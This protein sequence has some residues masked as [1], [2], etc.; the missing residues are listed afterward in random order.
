MRG[1]IAVLLVALAASAQDP[2]QDPLARARQLIAGKKP[3]EALELLRPLSLAEPP[4]P[5]VFDAMGEACRALRKYGDALAAYRRL[6]ELKP[7]STDAVRWQALMHARLRQ[8]PAAEAKYRRLLAAREND[9][10]SRVGLAYT[11]SLQRKLDEAATE[12]HKA[13][14]IKPDLADAR[15]R[16][17]WILLWRQDFAKAAAEFERVLAANADDVEAGLGLAAVDQAQDRVEA[18]ENRLADLA[19]LHPENMDVFMAYARVLRRSGKPDES[20]DAARRVLDSGDDP[21]EAHM[22]LGELAV[23][24][25]RHREGEGHYRAVLAQEPDH[26]GGLTGLA[27]ALRRQGK[28]EEARRAYRSILEKEPDHLNARIGLAWQHAWDGNYPAAASEFYRVLGRDPRNVDALAGIARVRFLQGRWD[29]S[30]DLYRRALAI[31]PY[32]GSVRE[33]FQM[34]LEA[35]QVR[36]RLS[37]RHSEEFERDQVTERDAIRLVSNVLSNSWRARLTLDTSVDLEARASYGREYNRIL[38]GD[39]YDYDYYAVFAGVHHRIADPWTLSARIGYGEFTNHDSRGG[40]RFPSGEDFLEAGATVAAEWSDHALSL[41]W[42]RSPLVIKDFPTF[43]LGVLALDGMA[44]RYVS[45]W[46]KD[47]LTPE[48]HENQV[49]A[50]ARAAFYSDDNSKVGFETTLRHRLVYDNGWRVGPFAGIRY[51][52][53]EEDVVFYYSYDR[54]WRLA[55]GIQVDY[56]DLGVWS[57]MARYTGTH[58]ITRE[59]V[60]PGQQI[61]D[62]TLPIDRTAATVTTDGSV[63]EARAVWTPGGSV[64]LGADASYSWD[65]NHYIT[66]G[67]G[68]FVEIGF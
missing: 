52:D 64:R 3:A 47:G 8:F 37:L 45:P 54:Q 56:E 68:L 14:A 38:R 31:D 44:L 10:E 55:G 9:L 26:M 65:N 27:T 25:Q 23:Q 30:T 11:L 51:A 34:A 35:G 59:R 39:N 46:W 21:L 41:E 17:G 29:E 20:A 28:R 22:L 40:W 60:N 48:W 19:R 63:L 50:A 32:D 61:F 4:D 53:F 57:F 43:D 58:A 66:W 24:A 2:P 13:L 33:G 49:E 36:A 67:T 18:A 16:L 62:P 1:S 7:G 42:S 5:A 15:I 6:E 12:V